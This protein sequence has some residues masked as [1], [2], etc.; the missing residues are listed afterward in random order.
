[1]DK[2]VD[3]A[4]PAPPNVETRTNPNEEQLAHVLESTLTVDPEKNDVI[5]IFNLECLNTYTFMLTT[6]PKSIAD[7]FERI[8]PTTA[9]SGK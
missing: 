1:M 3:A 9:S 5:L 7:R 8:K 4:I 6:I 2:K